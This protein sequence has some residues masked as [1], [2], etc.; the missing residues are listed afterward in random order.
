MRRFGEKKVLS[1]ACACE[2]VAATLYRGRYGQAED[3]LKALDY[4]IR[5]TELGSVSSPTEISTIYSEGGLIT[6]NTDRAVMFTK[7]AAVRGCIQGHHNLG[8]YECQRGNHE[9]GIRHWKIAAEGGSQISLNALKTIYNTDGKMPG[10]EFI[11]KDD[12]D[13]LYRACHEA[14][15][16]VSSEERMK[17]WGSKD[18]VFKC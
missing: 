10:K 9:A 14:Q 11:S 4:F 3:K 2:C 18:D 7:V 6:A 15:E 16:E 1:D 5:A 17:H 8:A 12:L 13:N